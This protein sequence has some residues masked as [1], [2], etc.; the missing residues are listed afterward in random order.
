M[1]RTCGNCGHGD[2]NSTVYCEVRNCDA[3]VSCESCSD[4]IEQTDTLE[5]RHQQLEQVAREAG[6]PCLACDTNL[7]YLV[8]LRAE[9]EAMQHCEEVEE[10][11]GRLAQVAREMWRW[12][13]GIVNHC[14]TFVPEQPGCFREQLEALG[15]SVD[16]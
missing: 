10:D 14:W 2:R 12:I 13:D 3:L 9:A 7:G 8:A 15:V 16:D 11:Y 4:W 6:Y 5:Q 1:E